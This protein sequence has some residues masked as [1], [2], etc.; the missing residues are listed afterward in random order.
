M[1]TAIE[2]TTAQIIPFPVG[3]VRRLRER[4]QRP[5][6]KLEAEAAR[7]TDLAFGGCWYHEE[8]ISGPTPPTG[9]LS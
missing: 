6:V 7:H 9:K 4:A 3:G 1:A 8:A 2:P 5:E